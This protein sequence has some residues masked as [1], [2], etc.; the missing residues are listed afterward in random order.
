M[1]RKRAEDAIIKVLPHVDGEVVFH[2]SAP[3]RP[4]LTTWT[5]A[6]MFRALGLKVRTG[7]TFFIGVERMEPATC[8]KCGSQNLERGSDGEFLEHY[9]PQGAVCV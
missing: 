7:D 4:E 3:S 6:G 8:E 9:G 1:S 5:I 2:V